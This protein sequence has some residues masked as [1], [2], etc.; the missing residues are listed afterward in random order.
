MQNK[1]AIWTFTI[2]LTLA[3]L[4]QI[5]YSWVT[6]SVEK[7]A[8]QVAL[9]QLDSIIQTKQTV[10]VYGS[11][12]YEMAKE[13]DVE[14]LKNRLTEDYL[15]KVAHEPAYPLLGESYQQ[16]KKQELS[17][18]LDLKGGMAVTLEV[19]IPDL[20]VNLAG[21][22]KNPTFRKAYESA[23]G[24]WVKNQS[25]DFIDLYA[26]EYLANNPDG[27]LVTPF[28]AANKD[29]FPSKM[30]NDELIAK[31]HTERDI[32]MANIEEIMNNRINKFG[33]SNATLQRLGN[34]GRIQIELPGVKDKIRVRNLLQ[35]TANLE[36]WETYNNHEIAPFLETANSIVSKALFPEIYTEGAAIDKPADSTALATTTESSTTVNPDS[37]K[38]SDSTLAATANNDSSLAESTKP[39]SLMND[40]ERKKKYPIY[41]YLNLAINKQ[42]DNSFTWEQGSRIG[43]SPIADTARLNGLLAH[44]G[45]KGVFPDD[46][47]LLWGSKP[48]FY[49][50]EESQYIS[51]YCIKTGR[52]G[53][54]ELD[55]SA[56][57]EARYDFDQFSGRVQVLMQMN[58]KGAETWANL[59][60]KNKGKAIAIVMDDY[61]YSA[62]TVQDKITGGR[63]SISGNFT[64]DE[65]N[66]LA[67][68]LKSGTLPA[69]A[70]IVDSVEVG[71]SLGQSNITSGLNSFLIALMIVLVYMYIYYKKAGLIA[72]ISLVANLFFL[73]GAL[74]SI[75]ASLTL[76]GIAGIVL[77]I[78]MAVDANVLIFERIREELRGGKSVKVAVND[79]FKKALSSIIDGNLTTLLT[80]IVLATFG[81][82]PILG[83]ATTLIIGIFTSL[84]SSIFI[85]RLIIHE[86]LERKKEISFSSKMTENILTNT[87]FGFIKGRKLYYG[88]ST[89][90]IL[91]GIAS[92]ATKGL[93]YGV[94]FSGGYAF[95]IQ[96]QEEANYEKIRSNLANVFV[97]DGQKLTPEVKKIENKFKAK[98]T[99]KFMI[100]D[101]SSNAENTVTEKLKEGL[102]EWEGKYEILG[103]RKVGPVISGE[104]IESSISA[105]IFALIIIFG[106]IVIRFRKWQFGLAA[107]AAL[108]HDALIVL[109]IFSMLYGILP[110]SLEIDQA[111]I[112]AILTVVGYSINDTVVVFDRVRE[113]LNEHKRMETGTL[114]DTALNSTLSRTINTSMTTAIVLLAIFLFGG[115]AIKGFTFALL[116]GVVV[117][118]YSSLFIASPLVYDIAGKNM[119]NGTYAKKD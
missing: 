88:I 113:Y 12:Q 53:V 101:T 118:T 93:D 63:S 3:C 49:N 102:N 94:E 34:S 78:G 52:K 14:N 106:Y 59:T 31:L 37:T 16:C 96:F 66:D 25:E 111:F 18:G 87:K 86:L 104:L 85:S 115:E 47:R 72:N 56:V 13:I 61:V 51:L 67:N 50:G 110:F 116:I 91:G 60:E 55:G 4:F 23:Y 97:E 92:L 9:D 62:P 119:G 7:E 1:S 43:F 21:K 112:A 74:A 26:A 89:I 11:D 24:K 33:V 6:N 98:V 79:G 99:T 76:P 84:F 114:F 29:K 46:L 90:L 58:A 107:V 105:I 75:Q 68:V 30:S 20:V 42:A 82:G 8:E 83:F 109:G 39:D 15:R 117:G 81:S 2:L 54:P 36:F 57:S 10:V 40:I 103:S 71:P 108:F 70:Q 35:S 65:A 77:T 45:L 41:S 100:N 95:E 64:V 69:R 44:P 80:A 17:L 38:T 5:S 48:D 27:K 19:S 73:I 22:S 28:S 32:A